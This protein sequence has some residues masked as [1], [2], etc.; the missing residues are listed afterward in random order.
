MEQY[1]NKYNLTPKTIK[2]LIILDWH[3][4]K[5]NTWHNKAML[6]GNWWCH[7]EGCNIGGKYDDTD[8]FWIGFNEDNNKIDCHFSCYEGMCHYRFKE[9]YKLD[10]IENVYDMNVQANAIKW[11]NTLI[12]KGILGIEGNI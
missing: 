12:D 4:L 5:K 9:F 1:P 11:L 10:E 3:R 2:K 8:E 7:L 6:S